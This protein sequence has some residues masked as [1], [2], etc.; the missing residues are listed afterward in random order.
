MFGFEDDVGIL[1]SSANTILK[2]GAICVSV[3]E[4]TYENTYDLT[5]GE[6]VSLLGNPLNPKSKTINTENEFDILVQRATKLRS[7]KPTNQNPTSSRSHL[8]FIMT[9][10]QNSAGKIVFA[11]LA[12][13]ETASGKEN[14]GETKHI[15]S[16]TSDINNILMNLSRGEVANFNGNPMTKFLKPYLQP[17][18]KTL[19]LYH[20]TGKSIRKGLELIKDFTPSTS[21]SKRSSSKDV[22]K[23]VSKMPKLQGRE[24]L[25]KI[26]SNLRR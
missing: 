4:F 12:G 11:D 18:S 22:S 9:F 2:H 21:G 20:V 23:D 6:K 15:N 26:E 17:P 7:Q 1:R 10:L 8:M 19:M 24:P 3:V 25:K 5:N 14:I 16:T 13:F